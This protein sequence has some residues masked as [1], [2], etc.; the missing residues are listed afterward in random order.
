MPPETPSKHKARGSEVS[1]VGPET[2]PSRYFLASEDTPTRPGPSQLNVEQ[3]PAHLTRDED[4][5]DREHPSGSSSSY[6]SGT[7]WND[8]SIM[9]IMD[10]EDG[11]EDGVLFD[12]NEEEGDDEEGEGEGDAG[13]PLVS[14]GR[15]R[16]RRRWTSEETK[17]E[18]RGLLEVS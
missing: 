6:E 3:T 9:E 2:P 12:E 16:R 1:T 11:L 13:Q 18:E 17:K 8:D 10:D 7:S 14:R 5:E 4:L 15:R